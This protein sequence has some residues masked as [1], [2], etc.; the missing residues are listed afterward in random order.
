[1]NKEMELV[2]VMRIGKIDIVCLQETK[3]R[4]EKTKEL[5]EGYKQVGTEI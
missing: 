4:G 1:M 5:T 3:R 2:N